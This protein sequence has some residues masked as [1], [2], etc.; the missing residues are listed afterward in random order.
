MTEET[1]RKVYGFVGPGGVTTGGGMPSSGVGNTGTSGQAESSGAR[2]GEQA[3]S[4]DLGT[5]AQ[6]DVLYREGARAGEYLARN[7]TGYPLQALLLA[8]FVG[9]GLGYLIHKQWQTEP[10]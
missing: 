1:S 4:A 2:A 5:A 10:T 6:A 8:G 3:R 9:Y 7:I